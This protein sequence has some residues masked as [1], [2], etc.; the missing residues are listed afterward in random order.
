MYSS[1]WFCLKM[2]YSFASKHYR[3]TQVG[4][5]SL[6]NTTRPWPCWITL[7]NKYGT[8]TALLQPTTGFSFN[9][10]PGWPLL[11]IGEYQRTDSLDIKIGR[12]NI[13]LARDGRRYVRNPGNLYSFPPCYPCRPNY[14]TF[15]FK[16]DRLNGHMSSLVAAVFNM[17]LIY[18]ETKSPAF[19]NDWDYFRIWQVSISS[20]RV[21]I[22]FSFT[23]NH[24]ISL[25]AFL[26]WSKYCLDFIA[27]ASSFTR[28]NS[29]NE[30]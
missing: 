22:T 9:R 20:C 8:T 14:C 27:I 5:Q 15:S 4:I 13:R 18:K 16:E 3:L 21:S 25:L 12:S 23:S 29:L 6:N 30:K 10:R 28:T 26:Y 7:E 17:R 2:G 24:A 1:A 19:S 11:S